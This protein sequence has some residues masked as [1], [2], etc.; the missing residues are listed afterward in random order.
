MKSIFAPREG[1]RRLLFFKSLLLGLSIAAPVGPIGLLCIN[2]TLNY[3]RLAGFLSGLG[4]AT[5]DMIYAAFAAFGFGFAV[6]RIVEQQIWTELIGALFLLYI[7]VKIFISK[8]TSQAANVS[9]KNLIN[10]F[11]STWLLTMANPVTILSFVAMFAGLGFVEQTGSL[12][13]A[14]T[15][16]SGVFLGSALWWLLLSGGVYIFKTKLMPYLGAVNKISGLLIVLLG[17]LSLLNW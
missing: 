10:M 13:A 1:R 17:V 12:S 16:V 9:G 7:G 5:A 14:F 6:R 15:L 11:V 4:A 8:P 3:G 2:R